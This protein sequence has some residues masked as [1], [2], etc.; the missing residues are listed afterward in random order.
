M[1]V[2]VVGGGHNGLVAACYLARAGVDVE[3]LEQSDRLGGGSRTDELLP[4]F[5][6]DTHSAAHNI[7]NATDIV[8]E[9]GLREAG[10]EYREMDPFSVAVFRGGAL[11]R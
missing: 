10:L 5:R 8:D 6:F 1:R 7:V 11:V 4:G 9:L 3:V 2:L